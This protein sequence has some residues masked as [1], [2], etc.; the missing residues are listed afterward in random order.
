MAPL[1]N[2]IKTRFLNQFT[3]ECERKK[4][5][6]FEGWISLILLQSQSDLVSLLLN[7]DA[8]V[9][10]WLDMLRNERRKIEL[11]MPRKRFTV[12]VLTEW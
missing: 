3:K 7:K 5:T 12:V 1:Y 9:D 8:A 2:E 10:T 4:L 11:N 6:L